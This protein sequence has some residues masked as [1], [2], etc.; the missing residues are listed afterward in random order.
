MVTRNATLRGINLRLYKVYSV[1][2]LFGV[3]GMFDGVKD[4]DFYFI[5]IKNHIWSH[6][7][8]NARSLLLYTAGDIQ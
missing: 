1:G 5:L 7:F 3:K 2:F 4:F 6:I 8:L